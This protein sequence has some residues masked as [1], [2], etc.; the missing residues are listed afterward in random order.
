MI[1]THSGYTF[2][3]WLLDSTDVTEWLTEAYIR[4]RVS[5]N[6]EEKTIVYTAK[7]T[8]GT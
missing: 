6:N 5:T 8:A 1:E 7:L 4:D 2:S 3:G